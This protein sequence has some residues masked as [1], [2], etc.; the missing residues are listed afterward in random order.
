MHLEITSQLSVSSGPL[1]HTRHKWWVPSFI[2]LFAALKSDSI[3]GELA[4]HLVKQLYGLTNKK[5][6][7]EQISRHYRQAHHFGALDSCDP[8]QG[9]TVGGHDKMDGL[10]ELHYMMSN[11][12]NDPVQLASFS[13]SSTQ[14]PAAKVTPM[15]CHGHGNFQDDFL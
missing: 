9:G 7:P 13:S 5:D 1:T 11:S 14:D 15:H 10:P 12:H 2:I 4:H 8:S 3:Q 6:A